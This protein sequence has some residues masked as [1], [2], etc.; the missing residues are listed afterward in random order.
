MIQDR[1]FEQLW[2]FNM[3]L[4]DFIRVMREKLQYYLD[5]TIEYEKTANEQTLLNIESTLEDVMRILFQIDRKVSYLGIITVFLE[6]SINKDREA[7]KW[8]RGQ[9]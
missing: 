5:K 3:E 4:K 2:E 9:K 8:R 6:M 1:Y 7:V